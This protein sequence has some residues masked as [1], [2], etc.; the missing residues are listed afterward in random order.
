MMEG[1]KGD[2]GG[3]ADLHCW[4]KL[5]AMKPL[6]ISPSQYS[7]ARCWQPAEKIFH[8]RNKNICGVLRCGSW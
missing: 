5:Q 6:S 3:S 2:Q 4:T 8:V 7:V 1:T